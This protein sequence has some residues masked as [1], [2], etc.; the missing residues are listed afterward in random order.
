MIMKTIID[1]LSDDEKK[2]LLTEVDATASFKD[3]IPPDFN[4]LIKSL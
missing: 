4:N 3:S 1:E 2:A